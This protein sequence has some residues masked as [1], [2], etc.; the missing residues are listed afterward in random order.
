M[1]AQNAQKLCETFRMRIKQMVFQKAS[2][3]LESQVQSA[4]DTLK[5]ANQELHPGG[6]G[7]NLAN[8]AV[9][10]DR[11]RSSGVIMHSEEE[12]KKTGTRA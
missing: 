12:E 3:L 7:A 2:E 11:Q 8:G 5:M 4:M 1:I 10:G 9:K 6:K